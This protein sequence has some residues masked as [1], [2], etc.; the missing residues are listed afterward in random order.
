MYC[1]S[2]SKVSAGTLRYPRIGQLRLSALATSE[3]P[4]PS[5]YLDTADS[6]D[7]TSLYSHGSSTYSN[8]SLSPSIAAIFIHVRYS[9]SE[10]M[11][12]ISAM[13]RISILRFS[14]PSTIP[15]RRS[16]TPAM[17]AAL[18]SSNPEPE[19]ATSASSVW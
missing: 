1:L 14:A 6:H 19:R 17:E 9:S 8:A 3:A 12:A 16:R 5:A 4:T 2:V 13:V 7:G 10:S 15:F 11:M 18:R